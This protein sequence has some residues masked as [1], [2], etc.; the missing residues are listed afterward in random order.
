MQNRED[1]LM[2]ELMQIH[3]KI[4]NLETFT[5]GEEFKTLDEDDQDLLF[6]QLSAMGGYAQVLKK[7]VARE[8][9]K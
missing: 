7:R 4:N 2:A 3:Q 5:E 8:L 1:R 6:E 9:L